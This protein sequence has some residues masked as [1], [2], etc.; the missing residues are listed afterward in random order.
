MKNL[1]R[2]SFTT[3]LFSFLFS[4]EKN[5]LA[6][7]E[8]TY[9]WGP[10]LP[11]IPYD[12]V[13]AIT[14][15][16]DWFTDSLTPLENP[17]T[18][19]GATLGR[20]LFYDKLLSNNNSVAC[21]S[22]HS[23]QY[24]YGDSKAFSTGYNQ[25]V[26][27][28]NAIPIINLSQSSSYFWDTRIDKLETMVIQPVKNHIEM[29]IEDIGELLPKLEDA[30]YYGPLFKKAFG[31]DY[32]DKEGI[33]AALAQYLRALI[34]YQSKYDEGKKINFTNYNEEENRGRTLFFDLLPCGDCHDKNLLGGK[35]I[36]AN[37]GLDIDYLDDGVG[38]LTGKEKNDGDFKIPSLRNIAV[39][40]PYMHDGRFT[41]LDEVVHFYNEKITANPN[42]SF[43][44][45]ENA[46]V[47]ADSGY[48]NSST[49]VTQPDPV[50]PKTFNLND[51]DISDIVSFLNTLTDNNYITD[52]KFSDPFNH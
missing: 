36:A 30:Q 34:T 40:A 45:S 31:S 7:P 42:L 41:T 16:P 37:I 13:T 20:V 39:T 15:A 12:Y 22:C 47:V 29:G 1:L 21:A 14:N 10:I 48:G 44:L 18:N 9:K 51:Q 2:C 4:C 35:G 27:L 52:E 5:H 33:R 32:I 26:T 24:S 43:P 11:L 19:D 8:N 6:A 38:D 50:I 46:V 3:L 25:E 49:V 17:I 23:A 28:R